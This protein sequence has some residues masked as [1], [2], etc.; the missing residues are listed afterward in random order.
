[1]G[2][3]YRPGGLLPSRADLALPEISNSSPFPQLQ[4]T[5]T[6]GAQTALQGPMPR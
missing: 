2:L 4:E 6:L 5:F 1:M 3:A